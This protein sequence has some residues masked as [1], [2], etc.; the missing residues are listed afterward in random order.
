M[1]TLQ[2]T[3]ETKLNHVKLNEIKST[4][5]L[6]FVEW[7]KSE[8]QEKNLLEQSREPTNSAHI[9]RRG[10]KLNPGPHWWKASALTTAPTLLP[11]LKKMKYAFSVLVKPADQLPTMQSLTKAKF[12]TSE[13][14]TSEREQYKNATKAMRDQDYSDTTKIEGFLSLR[15]HLHLIC[16]CAAL[17]LS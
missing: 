8:Y 1:G 10:Q 17:Q 4:Q 11:W 3:N 12:N 7:G 13:L 9:W 5:M 2:S 15:D 6:L 16:P 14:H